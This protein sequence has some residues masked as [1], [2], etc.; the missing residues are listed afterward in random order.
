M[1]SVAERGFLAP[2]PLPP[3]PQLP[4]EVG[5]LE[6]NPARG[7][8]EHCNPPQWVWAKPQPPTILLHFKDPETLLMTSEMCIFL[9]T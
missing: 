4:I 8:E 3:R 1:K 7:L 6:V 9:C 2:L 5:V